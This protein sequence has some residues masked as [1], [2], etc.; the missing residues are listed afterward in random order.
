MYLPN[1]NRVIVSHGHSIAQRETCLG[2][3]DTRHYLVEEQASKQ[4]RSQHTIYTKHVLS[5][6]GVDFRPWNV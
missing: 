5:V 4:R 6:S 2:R 1:E 3:C